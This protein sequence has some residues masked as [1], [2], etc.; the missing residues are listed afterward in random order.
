ML[1]LQQ[2]EQLLKAVL[3]EHE[4]AGPVDSLEAHRA[5]RSEKLA[6]KSLGTLV[7]VLFD[8]YAVADGFERE[9]LLDGTTPTDRVSMAFSH[10]IVMAPDRLAQTR[11]AV[12]ELVAMRNEMVHHL[13]ERFDLWSD[14]GCIAAKTHL[15]ACY[16]RV[17][18][19]LHQLTAWARGMDEARA[20][21]AAFA[22]TGV[23]H[24]LVVN[25]IAPDG[26]FE[27]PA[28]GIVSVLRQ[29]AAEL[30]EGGW[31]RLERVL[32]WMA[33]EH[34]EQ[35]PSKYG[36]RTWPQVLHD[37]RLFDLE[38]RRADD[39]GKVAWFRERASS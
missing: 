19:H 1:R 26:S 25:G 8:S 6:D 22:R 35:V 15:E 33:A 34:P 16:A 17:D 39:G 18:E 4:L 2:Y 31:A 9:L 5:A 37:S 23:F 12:G 36:C 20:H 11:A 13:I 24:D 10:R 29:A 28:T 14:D 32:Q 30:S 7:K 38:Y 21:V 3:A 27:W